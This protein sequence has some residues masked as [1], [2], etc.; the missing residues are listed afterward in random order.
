MNARG[1]ELVPI[2]QR[3]L[4]EKIDIVDRILA[5]K[6]DGIRPVSVKETILS[7]MDKC[8]APFRDEKGMKEGLAVI[9]ALKDEVPKMVAADHKKYNLELME[10]IEVDL[11]IDAAKLTFGSALFRQESRGH[12]NRTDFPEADDTNWRCHTIAAINGE[13]PEYG[14]RDV[15]YTRLKPEEA[16]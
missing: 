14:K 15:I 1:R 11:M 12:H 13:K 8:I 7:T 9:E 4:K 6:S 16:G 2:D 3:D 5:A 10:A